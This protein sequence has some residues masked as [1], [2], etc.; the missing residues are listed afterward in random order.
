MKKGQRD[1]LFINN[2]VIII[3]EKKQGF[4]ILNRIIQLVTILIG[5]WGSFGVLLD[6][7]QLPVNLQTLQ[8]AT[9]ISIAL[10]FSLCLIQNLDLVKLFF[11]TLIY[12][13]FF[14]NRL[15]A[16]K[17]GFYLLENSVIDRLEAYYGLETQHYIAN[18]ITA[19]ADST[20]LVVMIIIPLVTLFTVAIVRNRFVAITSVLLFL[21]ITFSF[22][23]GL[24][25]SE[26][27]MIA[28]AVAVLY[29]TRSGFSAGRMIKQEQK[30]RLHRI[31]SKAAVWLSLLTL[32]IFFMIKQFVSE[33]DYNSITEIEDTKLEL[34]TA[35]LNFTIEDFME[36][37]TNFDLFTPDGA[38]GGLN[39][40]KLGGVDEVKY[41][42]SEHLQI[43]ADL[44]AIVNGVYLKGYVG[45]VYTGNSWT[46]HSK[47]IDQLY[48]SLMEKMSIRDSAYVNQLN[49]LRTIV[50]KYEMANGLLNIQSGEM[51]VEYKRAN[52]RYFYAPYYTDYERM[53]NIAYQKDLYAVLD[54]KKK[55]YLL[56]YYYFDI[57]QA[58]IP[59]RIDRVIK[60]S[61]PLAAIDKE[62]TADEA[63]YRDFVY[64]AYTGLP[65]T[66]LERLKEECAPFADYEN[67]FDKIAYVQSYLS[68]QAKYSLSPGKLPKGKDFVEYFLYENKEG[69]CAHFASAATLMLRAMGVPARYVEG[70]VVR[71]SDLFG[72]T[73]SMVE[74]IPTNE[75]N[76][77][78]KQCVVSVKDYN[79]HAWVEVYI[80]HYGWIPIEV[81]PGSSINQG[82]TEKP[83]YI[84][85]LATK[86]SPTPSPSPTP[87][88][89]PTKNIEKQQPAAET[90]ATVN[91][92]N[93]RGQISWF[94]LILMAVI[95]LGIC[96]GV[97]VV[98]MKR[99]K[100][101]NKVKDNNKKAIVLFGQI[102]K[103]IAVSSLY[104]TE[105]V[106]LEDSEATEMNN[107]FDFN[108]L[109]YTVCME[110]VRKARFGKG[111][112][113]EE[114]LDAIEKF[115][116]DLYRNSQS[117]LPFVKRI[118]LKFIL[119][120]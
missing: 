50:E 118:Y 45:S 7:M 38:A 91:K 68:Y 60:S 51:L 40:G 116:Q 93:L 53:D 54:Q 81:T 83:E 87:K 82:T 23:F 58:E 2:S 112:I 1:G 80:D 97:V 39:G 6:C 66:G 13:L 98:L 55:A 26:R 102:E 36:A 90:S 9:L 57:P 94:Y 41:D 69:Y 89:E 25:P 31:N 8:M 47:E 43:T 34:Q 18:N 12:A 59:N 115:Y 19:S 104:G 37:I 114:E 35:L 103:I 110:N 67:V 84:P 62:Y 4:P 106:G 49:Q 27:Y 52:R 76:G 28:Y 64:K 113:S 70:Y 88:P 11:G 24:I 56:P 29:L 107:G 100:E 71:P 61:E 78:N 20:I 73:I 15:P 117:K 3:D 74:E 32:L 109:D 48:E 101:L 33:E 105:G 86:A 75:N 96:F 5:S 85:E 14:I 46:G 10:V 119:S 77:I 108:F 17:N 16:I 79:A 42:N 72:N 44:T 22:L 63:M 30:I 65:D 99:R 120:I 111:K 21:P 95:I 92:G